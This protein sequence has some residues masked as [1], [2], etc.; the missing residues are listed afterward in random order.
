MRPCLHGLWPHPWSLRLSALIWPL[1]CLSQPQILRRPL[2]ILCL[3]TI[4]ESSLDSSL[5]LAM[6]CL[7][8][9]ALRQ[10]SIGT[11]DSVQESSPHC[12]S[13]TA[14]NAFEVAFVLSHLALGC[15]SAFPLP[16]LFF[17]IV[18]MVPDPM[19]VLA[20]LDTWLQQEGD[21][22]LRSTPPCHSPHHFSLIISWMS[23]WFWPAE[24]VSNGLGS[25]FTSSDQQS[26]P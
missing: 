8:V 7:G 24:I 18:T 16:V 21:A 1:R 23:A 5:R 25:I 26:G 11:L 14:Q 10:L 12:A 2:A 22:R 19:F 13:H 3:P 17:P 4:P 6:A 20:C 15:C 9:S